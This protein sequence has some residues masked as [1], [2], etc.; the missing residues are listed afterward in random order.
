MIITKIECATATGQVLVLPYKCFQKIQL[1]RD[2]CSYGNVFN[3]V[4]DTSPCLRQLA[5]KAKFIETLKVTFVK[6]DQKLLEEGQQPERAYIALS[7]EM[8]QTRRTYP[9]LSAS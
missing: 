2:A 5:N 4:V 1:Y 8:I 6:K 7:G 3:S 9:C